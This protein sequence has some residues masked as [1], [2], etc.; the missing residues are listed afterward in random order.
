MAEVAENPAT[1]DG[2]VAIQQSRPARQAFRQYGYAVGAVGLAFAIR[3]A[4]THDRAGCA[5]E[6]KEVQKIADIHIDHVAERRDRRETHIP[7]LGPFDHSG[8]DGARL[9][10]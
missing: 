4:L 5:I 7:D 10:D 9:R 6:G 2:R 1:A 8:H 3:A